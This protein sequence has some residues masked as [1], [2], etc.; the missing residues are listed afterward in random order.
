MWSRANANIPLLKELVS[1][2]LR[3]SINIPLLRS[4]ELTNYFERFLVAS[5]K[6][7]AVVM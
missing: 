7:D 2:D 1:F 4:A 3:L 5:L 6:N